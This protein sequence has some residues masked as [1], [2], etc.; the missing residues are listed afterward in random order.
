M[1][2][3]EYK[4]EKNLIFEIISQPKTPLDVIEKVKD[5]L[6]NVKDRKDEALREYTL[7]FDKWN[8]QD[9]FSAEREVLEKAWNSLRDEDKKAILHA[10]KRIEDYHKYQLEK[11]WFLSSEEGILGM[12]VTPI[13]KMGA[14][15][16]GGR[17][18]L[19]STVL[20]NV[21]PAKIAGV[22]EIYVSSPAPE[23]YKNP[24]ILGCCYICE[25]EKV[26]LIGGA[27]AIGAFAFGTESVPK[28]D[29]IVGPGNIYVAEA[30]R[31]V[32]GIVGIDSVA[33][34]SEI[35]IIAD[36]KADPIFVAADLLSQAEHDPM[37][38][39]FLVTTSK[40]L[41]EQTKREIKRQIRSLPTKETAEK[42]LKENGAIIIV[43][44]LDDAIEVA[45]RIAPEHL[46]L[47]VEEPWELLSKI[48]SAGAIFLGSWSPEPIGDYIAGPN[49]T[50]PT[51][52]TAR[53]SSPLG[54][55]DFLKRTSIIALNRAGFEKI[56][57][58]GMKLA[59]IE[60]LWAH[61]NSIKVR[62]ERGKG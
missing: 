31:Q 10:K 26:F 27:Q 50:L 37:A 30:K 41:A 45:N 33:G 62:V 42:S 56:A 21:I 19:P 59:E 53:F 23:G 49:H 6:K 47:L 29:K 43:E 8:P 11:S 3:V 54:V 24:Y 20:M 51:G 32:F 38:R 40:K 60:G 9:G 14:Y 1:K 52:G 34:P 4:S 61:K 44:T 25:V 7:L 22:K 16:P 58:D 17:A 57:K 18:S 5:I 55:Y 48:K 39:T 15:V 36:D 46:E 13:E 2:T 12:M 28:V 35:L